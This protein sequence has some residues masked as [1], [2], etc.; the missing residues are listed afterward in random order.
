MAQ[1]HPHNQPDQVIS[2]STSRQS[3]ST[4][5]CP[6]PDS[7]TDPRV[8][9]LLDAVPRNGKVLDIGCVQHDAGKSEAQDWVHQHLYDIATEVVGLDYLESEV[10][11]LNE[12][13]YNVRHGDAQ[14]FDLGE[15]FDTIVAGELIEHLSNF[16]A[17]LDC[18][19]EHLKEDGVLVLTTPNPWSFY[20]VKQA[21]LNGR[22]QCNSEHTCWLDERTLRQVLDRHGFDVQNIEYV[23]PPKRGLTSVL[24]DIGWQTIGS[25]SL[26]VTAQP[27]DDREED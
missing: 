7:I 25:T 22:V 8:R 13:G 4:V 18:C 16:G 14:S 27:K 17:F 20:N 10:E 6:P 19:Y 9:A 23:R 3:R 21:V 24:F 15:S 2:P 1:R 26:L 11:K 12:R 5:E